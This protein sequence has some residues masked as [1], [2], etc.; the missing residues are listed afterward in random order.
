MEMEALDEAIQRNGAAAYVAIGS[1]ADAD[2]RYLTRFR[3]SDPII[4][5]KRQGEPGTIIVSSM[6]YERASRESIVRVINRNES[7]FFEYL[8]E[9]PEN[10]RRATARMIAELAH[11]NIVVPPQF[12]LA[13]ARELEAFCQVE[14]EEGAV[15]ELRAVK[16]PW[17]MDQIRY[18][19]Q[20]AE[21]A[22]G[23]ALQACAKSRVK[24]G[25]LT[26]DKSP[27][28]SERV[29]SL[30][31]TRLLDWGCL[32]HDTIVSCGSD[33]AI[34][35]L[36]GTGPLRPDEPII[37]DLF[38]HHEESG[39]FADMTRTVVKGEPSP[40]IQEMYQAVQN[41]QEIAARLLQAGIE[42]AHVHQAVV[43]F[44]QEQGYQSNQEG[45]LHNLG[46][47]VGLE[48]HELPVLGSGGKELKEG[49]V[50][51]I[52][53]GLYYRDQ[54]GVRLEDMGLVLPNGFERF[55]RYEE[56]LV[57]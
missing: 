48:V 28:T 3:T 54:G 35:H 53:P 44:F 4:Y 46:H 39:Y 27:L 32:V 55:T 16:S 38:P 33:T 29:K 40:E 12:P 34:P 5:W 56:R 15:A 9:N 45:F 21:A 2:M 25:V 36:T 17:E 30:I 52:E 50:V 47:G 18:V 23:A 57:L 51:T 7:G 20:A 6:E 19:Q 42:G 49:N 41:A 22:M 13:L 1:S 26:L 10:R 37:V 11:G 31:A 24:N 14:V 8:K 43:D